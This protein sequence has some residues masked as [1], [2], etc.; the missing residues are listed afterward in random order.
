M[1]TRVMPLD[2]KR[3]VDAIRQAE[4]GTRA[5]LICV[6][7][8]S[9]SSYAFFPLLW[10]TLLAL[11]VPAGL[12]PFTA[13]SAEA[14][15]LT[16]MLVFVAALGLLSWPSL[17][18]R[19]VPRALQRKRAHRA[20]LEQFVLRGLSR[21]QDR[22]GVLIFVSQAE[23]Y[24]RIIADDGVSSLIDPARWRDAIAVLVENARHGKMVE[25]YCEAIALC[26]RVLAEQLP[27]GD[28]PANELP[29][30]FFVI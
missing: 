21:K 4:I 18:L 25:G 7:A 23:R 14:I 2:E 24:A 20:A 22:T 27:P 1:V 6:M 10:A 17:R 3:I 8:R 16:Q 19:L 13:W 28:R 26:G 11:L 30:R 9:S 15:Y 12:L 5:E 29:N